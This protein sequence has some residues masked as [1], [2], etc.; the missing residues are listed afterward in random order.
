VLHKDREISLA[1][2]IKIFEGY[3]LVA[4]QIMFSWDEEEEEKDLLA[5]I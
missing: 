3:N 5:F 1:Q 4:Y 2:F